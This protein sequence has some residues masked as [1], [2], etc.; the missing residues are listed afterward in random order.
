MALQGVLMGFCAWCSVSIYSK[1]E[2]RLC[3]LWL[4]L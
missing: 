1:I 3:A 4:A 2:G